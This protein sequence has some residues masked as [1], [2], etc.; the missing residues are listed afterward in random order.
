MARIAGSVCLLLYLTSNAQ[1][2]DSAVYQDEIEKRRQI[3]FPKGKKLLDQRRSEKQAKL[4]STKT[5]N[6]FAYWDGRDK[7]GKPRIAFHADAAISGRNINYLRHRDKARYKSFNDLTDFYLSLPPP[8]IP[9]P[10]I[11]TTIIWTQPGSVNVNPYYSQLLSFINAGPGGGSI[12]LN[13]LLQITPSLM[14][15]AQTFINSNTTLSQVINS[16]QG[17]QVLAVAQSILQPLG[18]WNQQTLNAWYSYIVPQQYQLQ[19]IL[20]TLYNQLLAAQVIPPPTSQ[21]ITSVTQAPSINPFE[22]IS[23][24]NQIWKSKDKIKI[25][26]RFPSLVYS[27]IEHVGFS[28]PQMV[29]YS[30]RSRSFASGNYQVGVVTEKRSEGSRDVHVLNQEGYFVNDTATGAGRWY[31]GTDDVSLAYLPFEV[32]NG[33]IETLDVIA[34]DRYALLKRMSGGDTKLLDRAS[35]HS[36]SLLSLDLAFLES[37]S[38]HLRIVGGGTP[39]STIGG[40]MGE[41][42]YG[43]GNIFTGRIGG[44][45]VYED[46]LFDSSDNYLGYLE[47]ENTI[48]TPYASII[49]DD[50]ERGVRAWGSLSLNI[51][52]LANRADSR[53]HQRGKKVSAEWGLQGEARIFPEIHTEMVTGYGLFHLSGGVTSA[54]VPGGNI[55]LDHPERTLG[56]YPIRYHIEFRTRLRLS[57]IIDAW[58]GHNPEFNIFDEILFLEFGFVTEISKIVDKTRI[59]ARFEISQCAIDFLLEVEYYRSTSFTD[60]R[61]G[62]SFSYRGIFVTALQSIKEKD[63]RLE[64]GVD[65]ASVFWADS[66]KRKGLLESSW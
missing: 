21:M 26:E 23:E 63:Y 47:T 28:E 36:T 4:R 11:N 60:V 32:E 54:V 8:P 53:P 43:D 12:T 65:I 39:Q 66:Y 31:Q 33:D 3:L 10:Q 58:D 41:I 57:K 42:E 55:D 38:L 35:T 45:V 18:M 20:T 29:I 59:G 46:T 7:T 25:A 56:L 52:A 44:G 50:Y 61:V 6:P 37:R 30:S 17:W 13:H 48:R 2:Q 19:Q 1:A 15:L 62:G 16:S 14:L 64:V 24:L 34:S 40:I 27:L 5:Q 51:S 22:V 49:S 9:P